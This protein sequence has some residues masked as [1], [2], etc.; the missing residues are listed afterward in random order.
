MAGQRG[1]HILLVEDNDDDVVQ[2]RDILDGSGHVREC[3]HLA[4]GELAIAYLRR[5]AG[6]ESVER[7]DL[8][9]LDLGLPKVDGFQVLGAMRDS[10]ELREIPVVVF[11]QSRD[12]QDAVQSYELG[13]CS[14][15]TKPMQA[16][17]FDE[18][19]RG[20][21]I[22]WDAIRLVGDV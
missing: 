22:Y 1:L 2:L 5:E 12:E 16:E 9:M 6:F 15:V 14:F 8:V 18:L 19:V 17:R 20:F 11:T 13:A 7:P 4:D 3:V 10:S 21:S